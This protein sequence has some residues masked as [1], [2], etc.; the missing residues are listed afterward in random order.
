[1]VPVPTL[2]G[3][4]TRQAA[5]VVDEGRSVAPNPSV[6]VGIPTWNRSGLLREALDSVLAQ[7]L[8]DIEVFVFDDGSTDD[9]AEV[10]ASYDDPRVR[11]VRNERNLGHPDNVTQILSAGT[12][13]YV[14]MLFDDDVMFPDHLER[15]VALLDAYPDAAAAHT[16]Y[17]LWTGDG[18][19]HPMLLTDIDRAGVDR[20][21]VD[22]AGVVEETADVFLPRLV[23]RAPRVWVATALMRRDRVAG[24]DFRAADEP[25]TDV[26]FWMRVALR[27]TIV[28]DPTPTACL[29]VT[30]G[31]SSENQFLAIDGD[32]FFQP[33]FTTVRAYQK[34]YSR[35]RREHRAQLPRRLVLRLL[36]E[37]TR[38]R[39]GLLQ[40]VVRRR[41][42]GLRPGRDLLPL[43][44]E[45][46][47]IDPSIAVDPLFLARLVGER[48]RAG[49]TARP[50]ERPARP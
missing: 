47:V 2:A 13:P 34:V 12:A 35:F 25:A 11:Y 44:R 38:T 19:R 46:L 48:R 27:G 50:V 41:L 49:F 20:A 6:T 29:R 22:R 45:A 1:V 39:H 16:A 31:Y 4:I 30:E 28:Y 21:G 42:P 18:G 24:L 8:R 17:E 23:R 43:L 5:G 37:E 36:A 14:A 9:T 7:T 33:T 32:G 10:M 26:M 40:A 15:T 3:R